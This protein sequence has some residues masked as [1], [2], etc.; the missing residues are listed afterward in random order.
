MDTSASNS[1]KHLTPDLP[2][3]KEDLTVKTKF[4]PLYHLTLEPTALHAF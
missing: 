4:S 3:S 1:K 2:L